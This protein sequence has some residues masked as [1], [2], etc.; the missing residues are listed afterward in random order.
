MLR[1]LP[2]F[3]R[4]FTPSLGFSFLGV[5]RWPVPAFERRLSRLVREF[6]GDWGGGDGGGG[7]LWAAARGTPSSGMLAAPSGLEVFEWTA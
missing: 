5:I 2:A 4:F 1:L 7:G 6:F 3:A